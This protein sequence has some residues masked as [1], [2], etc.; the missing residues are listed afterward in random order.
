MKILIF[1]FKKENLSGSKTVY[2]FYLNG[3]NRSNLKIW[4][5][6]FFGGNKQIQFSTGR[7][8]NESNDNSINGS[9]HVEVDENFN[10]SLSMPMN[11]FSNSKNLS[12][13]DVVKEIYT[14]HIYPYLK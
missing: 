10:F 12:F 14:H 8:I 11:M 13:E 9:V 1:I 7:Y 4:L 2:A 3:Q 6:S 5:G